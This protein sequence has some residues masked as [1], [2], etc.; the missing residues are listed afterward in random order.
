MSSDSPPAEGGP[1][2]RPTDDVSC[3]RVRGVGSDEHFVPLTQL[4]DHHPGGA[5]ELVFMATVCHHLPKDLRIPHQLRVYYACP[6][7]LYHPIKCV[8]SSAWGGEGSTVRVV[9]IADVSFN[10]V[11]GDRVMLG[12]G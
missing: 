1:I 11:K 6:R 2:P 8:G 10:D 12:R 9:V 4:N 7:A 3:R 5:V